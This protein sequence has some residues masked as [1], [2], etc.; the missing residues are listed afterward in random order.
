LGVRGR[1]ISEFKASLVYRVSSRTARVT[2]R[3]PVSKNKN[4]H[5]TVSHDQKLGLFLT[6][7]MCFIYVLICK[8]SVEDKIKLTIP[9]LKPFDLLIRYAMFQEEFKTLY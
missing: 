9:N 6:S 7:L 2:Q 4:N 1:K 3:N 5:N 8:A